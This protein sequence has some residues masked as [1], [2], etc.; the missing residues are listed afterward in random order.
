[1]FGNFQVDIAGKT[2]SAE[3]VVKMPGYPNAL[4]LTQSWWCGYG[5]YGAPSIVVCALIENGG[6]GG[7][8]A[9]PTALKVF[10]QYFKKN[11]TVTAHAS[12]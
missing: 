6:H 10:E 12:D 2:G 9:A 4:K 1:M 8:A 5:P 11:A 3:K 7:D